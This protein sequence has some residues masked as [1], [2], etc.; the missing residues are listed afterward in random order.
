MS[1]ASMSLGESREGEDEIGMNGRVSR[2]EG[3]RI[4]WKIK[5]LGKEG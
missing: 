3:G 2:Q 5:G 4:E 1:R